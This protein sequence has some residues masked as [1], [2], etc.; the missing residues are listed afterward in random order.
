MP[1]IEEIAA[2]LSD[3]KVFTVLDIKD[4]FWHIKLTEE[5]SFLTT[6]NTPNGRFRWLRMPFGISSGSEEF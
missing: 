5:A 2:D 6:F 1:T 4:G 3:A